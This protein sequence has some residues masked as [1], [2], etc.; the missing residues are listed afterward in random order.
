MPDHMQNQSSVSLV[1]PHVSK[2]K[3]TWRVF[4]ARKLVNRPKYDEVNVE[5]P[6]TRC[7]RASHVQ[8]RYACGVPAAAEPE[9]LSVLYRGLWLTNHKEASWSLHDKPEA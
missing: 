7:Q 5:K 4:F 2:E 1:V 8:S 3:A 6:C 9:H